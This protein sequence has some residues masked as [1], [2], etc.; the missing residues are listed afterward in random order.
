MRVKQGERREAFS[1]RAP[2]KGTKVPFTPV[3][4]TGFCGFDMLCARETLGTAGGFQ[5]PRPRQRD[6][7]PLTPVPRTGF[8]GFDELCARGAQ[9]T[10]VVKGIS[11]GQ[12]KIHRV[13]ASFPLWIFVFPSGFSRENPV[14]GVN[15]AAY[16][17]YNTFLRNK[18]QQPPIVMQA[19]LS[20]CISLQK[21]STWL[22]AVAYARYIVRFHL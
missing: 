2:D 6:N 11:T 8:C 12:E 20:L 10:G 18:Y 3:P 1:P 21:F 19:V 7:V 17:Q 4:R 15:A 5:P 22:N 9:G 14:R 13:K 16:T